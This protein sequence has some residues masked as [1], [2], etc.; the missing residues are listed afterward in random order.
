MKKLALSLVA[1]MAL[2]AGSL[3]EK[4]KELE[5]KIEAINA[6]IEELY[7]RADENEFQASLNKIKWGAEFET[8]IANFHGY[9]DNGTVNSFS[10]N[11]KVFMKLRLNMHSKI[12]EKTKFTGRLSMYKY[13]G[14]AGLSPYLQDS[15]EGRIDGGST[16]YVE[17]AYV[18]YKITPNFIATIG[19][20]PSS[21]GPGKSLI[22]DT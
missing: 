9:D 14:E 18:D 4:V 22:N 21:D 5:K 11:G 16:L 13:W 3:E 17:R 10:N 7:N 8:T 6:D 19:R 2:N 20:Q 15:N 12:N 1:L